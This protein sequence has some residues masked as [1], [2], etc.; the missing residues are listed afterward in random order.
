MK[1]LSPPTIHNSSTS[2]TKTLITTTKYY[3][4]MSDDD[5][6]SESTNASASETLNGANNTL[7]NSA[8]DLNNGNH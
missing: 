1:V 6:Q 7:Q 3:S 8:E 2:Y 4:E 5:L